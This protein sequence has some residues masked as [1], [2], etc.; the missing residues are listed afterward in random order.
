[1][2]SLLTAQQHILGY[3]VPDDGEN[4]MNPPESK[5][6]WH[7]DRLSRYCAVHGRQSLYFATHHPFPIKITP[8]HGGSEPPSNTRL[9]G[10]FWAHNPNDISIG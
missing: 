7:L 4:V 3:L 2:S 1:V 10:P 8:S 6:K 5:P 9:L